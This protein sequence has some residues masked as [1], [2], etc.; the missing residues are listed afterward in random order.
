MALNLPKMQGDYELQESLG[1][2]DLIWCGDELFCSSL[3]SYFDT[4]VSREVLGSQINFVKIPD[5]QAEAI[6]ALYEWLGV[7]E[8]P[9]PSDIIK[10]IAR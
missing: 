1:N 9:R 4:S 5:Q 8:E 3:G 7:V 10:R 6:K 2:L